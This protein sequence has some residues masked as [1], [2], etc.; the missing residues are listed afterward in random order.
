MTGAIASFGT[1][2]QIGDGGTPENFTTIAEVRDISGPSLELD[3]EEVTSHDSPG[4]W[5][6][7]VG[8]ILHGGEVEF[9]INFIPTETTHRDAAGGLLRDMKNRT[10]RNFKLVFPDP[11][12]TTWRFAA[13]VTNFEPEASVDGSLSASVTLRISG[14]PTLA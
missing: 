4:G 6:E 14:Q 2:L 9:D 1:L 10:L 7:V 3:V 12:N 5:E 8:T 11:G 13:L